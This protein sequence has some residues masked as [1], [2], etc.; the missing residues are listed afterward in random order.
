MQSGVL[1]FFALVLRATVQR[2]RIDQLMALNWKWLVPISVGNLLVTAFLLQVI[3]ALGL[4]PQNGEL[5]SA[6]PQTIIL[7]LGNVLVAAIVV[8]VL[9][10]R[11]RSERLADETKS[12]VVVHGHDDME[13][14]PTAAVGD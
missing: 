8:Q 14:A 1:Y 11:G 10:N 12:L 4:T 7:F 2:V 9:R 6:L 13:H 3:K 5:G